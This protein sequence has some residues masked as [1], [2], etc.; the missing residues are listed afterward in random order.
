MQQVSVGHNVRVLIAWMPPPLQV[1]EPSVAPCSA[2]NIISTM[3]ASCTA[4]AV[5]PATCSP[6]PTQR[7]ASVCLCML[8][9]QMQR[10][11]LSQVRACMFEERK[12]TPP[13]SPTHT[14][15]VHPARHRTPQLR[16]RVRALRKRAVLEVRRCRAAALGAAHGALDLILGTDKEE[17]AR[18]QRQLHFLHRSLPCAYC[19][20]QGMRAPRENTHISNTKS[21]TPSKIPK[22]EGA[23]PSQEPVAPP[24]RACPPA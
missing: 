21:S 10:G 12:K 7:N 14:A 4:A 2:S 11:T 17:A 16:F 19:L 8:R 15:L 3:C 9:L 1:M 22:N 5:C 13:P 18:A 6:T 20:L 24:A 23:A